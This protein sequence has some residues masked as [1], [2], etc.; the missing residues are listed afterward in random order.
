M[1]IGA[2]KYE[3]GYW[4]STGGPVEVEVNTEDEKK[5]K[6]T[7]TRGKL[8]AWYCV[9]DKMELQKVKP[10]AKTKVKSRYRHG[11]DYA[12]ESREC[13][14]NSEWPQF[15]PF[16]EK[17]PAAKEAKASAVPAQVP[18]DTEALING[19][20]SPDSPEVSAKG[21]A[22]AEQAPPKPEALPPPLAD[23]AKSGGSPGPGAGNLPGEVPQDTEALINGLVGALRA[24]YIDGVN[25]G[26]GNFLEQHQGNA[27]LAAKFNDGM[28]SQVREAEDKEAAIQAVET[29]LRAAT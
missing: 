1:G 3:G 23:Q 4:Y 24:E 2:A 27:F 5:P 29:S 26:V 14:T 22:S 7:M 15:P 6:S 28:E 10:L 17:P 18:Q 9:D 20:V 21:Q 13:I 8:Q 11:P 12:V 16:P 19:L 25:H